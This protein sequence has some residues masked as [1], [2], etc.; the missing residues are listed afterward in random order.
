MIK[1]TQS[2]YILLNFYHLPI[3]NKKPCRHLRRLLLTV[4]VTM[5]E[6]LFNLSKGQALT[7]QILGDAHSFTHVLQYLVH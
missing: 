5:P 3:C 2:K 1:Q 7:N 4:I 6:Y